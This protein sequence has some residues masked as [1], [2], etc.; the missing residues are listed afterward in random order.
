MMSMRTYPPELE[1][2]HPLPLSVRL[3]FKSM[4]PH[5]N[6]KINEDSKLYKNTEKDYS[7]PFK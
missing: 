2:R 5:G 6:S 4:K 1:A 7:R 3:G